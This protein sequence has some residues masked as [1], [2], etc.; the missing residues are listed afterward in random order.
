MFGVVEAEASV[1]DAADGGDMRRFG[2]DDAGATGRLGRRDAGR[3]SRC[4]ARRWA[5]YWHIGDDDDAVAGGD[6]PEADWLEK[7]RCRHA[8]LSSPE[9]GEVDIA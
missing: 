6:R 9:S 8:K 5:L 1:G 7:Q 3:A 4:P 2:E